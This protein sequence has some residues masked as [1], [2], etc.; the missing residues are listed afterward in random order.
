MGVNS[1]QGI[2][3]PFLIGRALDGPL[4]PTMRAAERVRKR[5]VIPVPDWFSQGIE[6]GW[7]GGVRRQSKNCE[8]LEPFN[9]GNRPVA[10]PR[11]GVGRRG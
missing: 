11:S 8:A 2:S 6:R 10:F 7:T 3:R 4:L 1:L 5:A 9:A